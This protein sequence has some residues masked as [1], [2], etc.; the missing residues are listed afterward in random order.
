MKIWNIKATQE[1]LGREICDNILFLHAVLGCDTTSGLYGIGKGVV[2]KKFR[3]DSCIKQQAVIFNDESSTK[4]EIEAAGHA[5]LVSLYKGTANDDLDSLRHE[6]FCQKVATST[7]FV[8]PQSLP[9]TAAATRYHSLRVYFQV[10]QWKG[11]NEELNPLDWGW[12]LVNGSL[13][14][15]ETDLSP[16]PPALLSVVHCNCKT[17][18]SSARCSCRK[19]GLECSLACGECRGLSCSNATQPDI[20]DDIVEEA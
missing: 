12:C 13:T 8:H 9:P 20:S 7:T 17:G 19:H 3:N 14:P 11:R 10:Q 15:Q 16:A 1:A 18:C 6:R 5:T 2:L 4:G